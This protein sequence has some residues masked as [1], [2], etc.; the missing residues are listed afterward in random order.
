MKD[1]PWF[2]EHKNILRGAILLLLMT[3]MLGPWVFDLIN[4]PAEY[5]CTTPNVRLY[6]DFCGMPLPGFQV[7]GWSIVGL[8]YMFLEMIKGTFGC[9]F[10]ELLVGLSILPLIPFLTTILSIWKK[11]TRRLRMVN[12][13]VWI[14]AFLA[15][16]PLCI[17]QINYLVIRLWGLWLYIVVAVCAIIFEITVMKISPNE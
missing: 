11:E 3:T 13:V 4:V 17:L 8:F 1:S 15:I 16:M 9:R 6:G 5:P 10:R 2:V 14:L 7:F 12:L